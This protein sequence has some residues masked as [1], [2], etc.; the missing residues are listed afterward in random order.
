MVGE[1][2]LGAVKMPFLGISLIGK[3]IIRIDPYYF[4]P[5]E[6]DVLIG[7]A[8]KAKKNLGWKSSISFPE[9]VEEMMIA[10]LEIESGL[11]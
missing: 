10:D 2:L 4:R 5:T 3:E 11:L 9:L 6:V 1:P 7:D 8:A